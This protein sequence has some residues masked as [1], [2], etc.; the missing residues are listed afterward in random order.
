[1][2]VDCAGQVG[3]CA[4]VQG[5]VAFSAAEDVVPGVAEKRVVSFVA[6]D[7]VVAA[8]WDGFSRLVT[9]APNRVVARSAVDIVVAADW[10]FVAIPINDVVVR[11]AVDDVVAAIRLRRVIAT[12]D[13]VAGTAID[14][15]VPGVWRVRRVPAQA[16]VSAFAV[17]GVVSLGA[18]DDVV[19]WRAR[20]VIRLR[21]QW[22][23][24]QRK[25]RQKSDQ[26]PDEPT[27]AG[28]SDMDDGSSPLWVG[29]GCTSHHH[30]DVC[31]ITGRFRSTRLDPPHVS[32]RT[33]TNPVADRPAH[34]PKCAGRSHA[35]GLM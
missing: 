32:G 10:G 7:D 13:V 15:V 11:A 2:I 3:S 6:E 4:A 19:I 30:G 34:L 23:K 16:V 5:V 18:S 22:H 17:D 24:H 9:V 8:I 33:H 20:E 28:G 29:A 31:A 12:N 25:S 27:V 26:E 35:L 21:S 14:R 1:M